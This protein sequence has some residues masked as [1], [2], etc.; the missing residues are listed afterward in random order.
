MLIQT[1]MNRLPKN[2]GS[3]S[4][5]SAFILPTLKPLAKAQVTAVTVFAVPRFLL[6]VYS[7]T[8]KDVLLP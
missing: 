6:Q 3:A 4:L 5:I 2:D 8:A 1:K 7:A